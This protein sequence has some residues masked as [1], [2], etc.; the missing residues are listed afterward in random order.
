M[1]LWGG[2]QV[3]KK[4]IFCIAIFVVQ[5]SGMM[6]PPKLPYGVA[7]RMKQ[8][9]WLE[10]KKIGAQRE[11][12][13]I[14]RKKIISIN[15]DLVKKNDYNKVYLYDYSFNLLSEW[16]KDL[17]MR[18]KTLT[19]MMFPAEE[20]ISKKKIEETVFSKAI[21][22]EFSQEVINK[23]ID[24]LKK[25]PSSKKTEECSDQKI[26]QDHLDIEVLV[27]LLQ[28][29]NYLGID[30]AIINSLIKKIRETTD[31]RF[32]KKIELTY[33]Q[34]RALREISPEVLKEIM[35][36]KWGLFLEKI[37]V[38]IIK[39]Y[40]DKEKTTYTYE[41]DQFYDSTDRMLFSPDKKFV[42]INYIFK[43]TTGLL[44]PNNMFLILDIE[45]KKFRQ[46]SQ[47]EYGEETVF[48]E[49]VW[50]EKNKIL[51]AYSKENQKL[52]LIFYDCQLQTIIK[53]ELSLPEN[54]ELSRFYI[55]SAFASHS[56]ISFF[57]S[58]GD[59]SQIYQSCGIGVF[60]YETQEVI[61]Y[62]LDKIPLKEHFTGYGPRILFQSEQSIIFT[63]PLGI[64]ENLYEFLY[65]NRNLILHKEL[66]DDDTLE[67]FTEH[68]RKVVINSGNKVMIYYLDTKVEIELS[69]AN[70]WTHSTV[71]DMSGRLLVGIAP[72]AIYFF[73]PGVI[74][75]FS[76][77]TGEEIGSFMNNRRDVMCA[78]FS[79][80]NT[81]AICQK[82]SGNHRLDLMYGKLIPDKYASVFRGLKTST[83]SFTEASFLLSLLERSSDK[84]GPIKLTD[85]EKKILELLDSR[86]FGLQ[87]MMIDIGYVASFD[88]PI[89]G[90]EN[91]PT[92]GGNSVA[93]QIPSSA[94]SSWWWQKLQNAGVAA[95]DLWNY[96]MRLPD[97]GEIR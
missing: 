81:L 52:E 50:V 6:S 87:E 19:G 93:S 61:Y 83:F 17:W 65:N 29:A 4:I 3:N 85:Q 57:Y 9:S 63:Y 75:F 21:N 69:D 1:G 91:K 16:E 43:D 51:Y 38:D 32:D 42:Y 82:D 5:I 35:R 13:E 90:S 47:Q 48:F 49:G 79:D 12:E 37:K 66:G 7:Q 74:Y 73:S 88:S 89:A 33:S 39:K 78:A 71:F 59:F 58:T 84:K 96:I 24:I 40:F 36:F 60:N 46:I 67:D 97:S 34:V 62:N 70:F 86:V 11:Q 92:N 72:R 45:N 28:C 80:E 56:K 44:S 14:R 64:K 20:E 68:G 23:L 54:Q 18:S 55:H 15:D 31:L 76:S 27:S 53:K 10:A 77:V 2:W 26:Y 30:Q 25:C 8:K 41:T 22:I 95:R 94:Q